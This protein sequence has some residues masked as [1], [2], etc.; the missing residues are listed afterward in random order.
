MLR[1]FISLL[2]IVWIDLSTFNVIWESS[3][4]CIPLAAFKIILSSELIQIVFLA[5]IFIEPFAEFIIT[6]LLSWDKI[7]DKAISPLTS[8][9]SSIHFGASLFT[10]F[11]KYSLPILVS[12]DFNSFINS[13]IFK[14]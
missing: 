7:D 14:A 6:E 1:S 5:L 2:S 11:S 13:T 10:I 3:I 12:P 8:L 4:S 9:F